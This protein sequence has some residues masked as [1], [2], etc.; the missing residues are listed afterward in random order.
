MDAIAGQVIVSTTL[1]MLATTVR[2]VTY[3]LTDRLVSASG[4][5]DGS[6]W[7]CWT[8]EWKESFPCFRQ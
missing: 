5:F 3:F 4:H 6:E 8:V 2:F 7:P 1:R